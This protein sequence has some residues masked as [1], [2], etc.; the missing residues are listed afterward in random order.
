MLSKHVRPTSLPVVIVV[1]SWV[2]IN[3]AA[4]L[5]DLISCCDIMITVRLIDR[6]KNNQK[7]VVNSLKLLFKF[8]FFFF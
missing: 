7:F 1:H 5:K 8:C 2:K 4:V 3:A 6:I